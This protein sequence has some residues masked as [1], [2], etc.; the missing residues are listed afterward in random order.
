MS[1][2]I[3]VNKNAAAVDDF[4]GQ[5]KV[6]KVY[7]IPIKG[8]INGGLSSFVKDSLTQAQNEG[9]D[10]VVFKISSF[11]GLVNSAIEIKDAIVDLN[12]PSITFV[13]ERAWSAGARIDKKKKKLVMAP[14]TSIG[15][16]ETRPKEEKYISAFRKEFSAVAEL[17]GRNPKIAEAMVD[18]DI[19]V[20]DIIEKGKLLTLTAEEAYKN[21]IS[22]MTADNIEE[23]LNNYGLSQVQI[24]EMEL[25]LKDKFANIVTN[26][27][28]TVFLLSLGFI[29]IIAEAIMPGWGVGG[30]IGLLSLGMFFSGYIINGYASWG[31]VVLFIVGIILMALELFVVPGFGITGIGGLIAVFGSLYFV[32]PDPVTALG[33]IAAVLVFSIIALVILIRLFGVS[34]F[35]ENISLGE[36]QSKATGY[37]SH[38]NKKELLGTQGEALTHIRPAGVA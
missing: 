22:D 33:V 34:K 17:R 25:S 14:G 2:L 3:S 6:E 35:W 32:F 19:K 38:S 37:T 36:S 12:L 29:S 10:L 18:A 28:F 21:K 31:L 27:F 16:A 4:P 15:A 20:K 9:A 30:T 24:I 23:V 1:V 13:E 5:K 26:P 11:G 7:L 8:D